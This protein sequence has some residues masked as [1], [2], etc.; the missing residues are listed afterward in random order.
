MQLKMEDTSLHVCH[1]PNEVEENTNGSLFINRKY[2]LTAT[3]PEGMEH[4]YNL[5]NR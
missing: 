1:D 5:Q 3:I 4:L 2:V